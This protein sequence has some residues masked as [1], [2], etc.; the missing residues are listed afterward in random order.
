[1]NCFL[2]ESLTDREFNQCLDLVGK[3]VKHPKGTELYKNGYLGILSKGTAKVR[4][5][6][7]SGNTITVRNIPSGE[8]FG[9]ASVFGN[10]QEGFSSVIADSSCEVYYISEK[11]LRDIIAI[12]PTVAL[13]YIT[14]LSEKIRFLNRRLDTFSAESTEQKIYEYLSFLTDGG[15]DVT[16]N[17][18]LSELSRRLKIGRTSLYRGLSSLEE[19]GLI[20]RN[21]S[22]FTIK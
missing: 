21:K 2:F 1:M 15:S 18:S 16:L 17:I 7:E 9:A 13:N 22:K 8:V 4:R 3:P 19:S 11:T 5:L 12:I 6:S 20:E 10:W 14:Y